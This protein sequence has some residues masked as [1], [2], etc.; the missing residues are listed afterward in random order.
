QNLPLFSPFAGPYS[1]AAQLSIYHGDFAHHTPFNY[2]KV[3]GDAAF[4]GLQVDLTDQP[5]G[6]YDYELTTT[7]VNDHQF[8]VAPVGRTVGQ[9]LNVNGK[10]SAFGRGWGLAGLKEVVKNPDGTFQLTDG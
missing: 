7:F 2:W 9:V 4:A 6:K 10:D 1:M 3:A 8:V 5:T